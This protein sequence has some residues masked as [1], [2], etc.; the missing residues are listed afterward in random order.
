MPR[1]S[2]PAE[3]LTRVHVWILKDDKEAIDTMFGN[4]IGFSKAIRTIVHQYVRQ[5]QAKAATQAKTVHV[6]AGDIEL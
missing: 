5:I 2:N 3:E 6:T 4:S 1:S